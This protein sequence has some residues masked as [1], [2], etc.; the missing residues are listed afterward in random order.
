MGDPDLE[1]A[2][3]GDHDYQPVFP[4]LQVPTDLLGPPPQVMEV[5][6]IRVMA[7]GLVGDR[8]RG[9][10]NRP[11]AR[12]LEPQPLE[13]TGDVDLPEQR[14]M[15][16]DLGV[17]RRQ[18]H[19][20]RTLPNRNHVWG[21][22]CLGDPGGGAARTQ[23][24]ATH[25]QVDGQDGEALGEAV[26][27]LHAQRGQRVGVVL[28]AGLEG[29]GRVRFTLAVANHDELLILGHAATRSTADRM[30]SSVTSTSTVSAWL[31]RTRSRWCSAWST[32]WISWAVSRDSSATLPR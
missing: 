23:E 10:L 7:A 27:V 26:G 22:G 28:V 20:R 31:R 6:L 18:V 24:A 5:L 12:I 13:L 2:A 29:V 15:V 9:M 3:V 30:N 4:R 1:D 32:A 14:R 16:S 11:R 8:Q 21:P 19:Q 25:D 17:V